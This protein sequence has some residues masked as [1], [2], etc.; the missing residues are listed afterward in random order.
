MKLSILILAIA[1]GSYSRT[2]VVSFP[3]SPIQIREIRSGYS[4]SN[5]SGTIIRAFRLSCVRQDTKLRVTF[6]FPRTE[7]SIQE[8]IDVFVIGKD[9][10]PLDL[11]RCKGMDSQLAV[12][13]VETT[14][15]GFWYL[16]QA[17]LC[18]TC[19]DESTQGPVH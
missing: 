12:Y 7:E 6:M 11:Q 5:K 8:G 15:G 2:S 18:K 1:L 14:D 17:E 3:S 19:S 10:P 4:L 9:G 16:R 13:E